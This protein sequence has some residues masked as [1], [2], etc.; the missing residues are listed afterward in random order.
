MP[1][2]IMATP[3][4]E[5]AVDKKMEKFLND[6]LKNPVTLNAGPTVQLFKL[7]RFFPTCLGH[8][9]EIA[10]NKDDLIFLLR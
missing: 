1:N 2:V 6:I 5:R 8:M 10:K 3:D 7:R 9:D 4:E